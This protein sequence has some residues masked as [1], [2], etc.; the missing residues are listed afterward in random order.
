VPDAQGNQW[1]IAPLTQE[2][3]ESSSLSSSSA[4]D[5]PWTK[6]ADVL[7]QCTGNVRPGFQGGYCTGPG[8]VESKSKLST[9][10]EAMKR[11]SVDLIALVLSPWRLCC[12]KKTEATSVK[13][14]VRRF[15]RTCR[16]LAL[17]RARHRAG[18]LQRGFPLFRFLSEPRREA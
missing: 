8:I 17:S 13:F 7:V 12:L 15:V 5:C 18:P 2:P 14:K 11:L 9:L 3:S 1:P 16:G 6:L 4:L 10:K